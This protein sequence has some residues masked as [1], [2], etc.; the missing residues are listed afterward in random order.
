M[1]NPTKNLKQHPLLEKFASQVPAE[2]ALAAAPQIPG[3]RTISGYLAKDPQ[4]GHWRLY[5]TLELNEF[6]TISEEDIVGSQLLATEAHPLNPN[7]VWVK[8]TAN[9]QHTKTES[10]Q[11]QAEFLTGGITSA[12]QRGSASFLPTGAQV[13]LRAREATINPHAPPC[14]S[15]GFGYCPSESCSFFPVCW[16]SV[17]DVCFGPT[18]GQVFCNRTDRLIECPTAACPTGPNCK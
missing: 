10:K 15:Q 17:N 2:A 5:L 9:L 6:L 16:V 7:L 13:G 4:E 12:F 18:I 14:A 3:V 11:I 8:S 1:E